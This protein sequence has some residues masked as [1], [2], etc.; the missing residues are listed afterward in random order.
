MLRRYILWQAESRRASKYGVFHRQDPEMKK[1]GRYL[2]ENQTCDESALH[3]ALEKQLELKEDSIFKPLGSILTESGTIAA[4]DLDQA[5]ALMHLERVADSPLFRDIS[6]DSLKQTLSMAEYKV[7]PDDTPVY[8]EGDRPESLCLIISGSVKVY[9]TNADNTEKSLAVLRAGDSLGEI[10][11]LTGEPHR[12]ST[13]RKMMKFSGPVKRRRLTSSLFPNRT[14][15]HCLSLSAR[16][17]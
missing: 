4:K 2:I 13:R 12:T 8:H 14:S 17:E 1:I 16:Q 5:L 11:L 10:A 6:G 9:I 15:W 3:R 7:L